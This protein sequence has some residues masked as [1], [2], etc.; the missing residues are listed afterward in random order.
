M[1]LT[2]PLNIGLS[3]AWKKANNSG[4]LAICGGHGKAQEEYAMKRTIFYFFHLIS[5]SDCQLIRVH[6]NLGKR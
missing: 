6:V 4:D 3:S 1:D 2:K 5:T